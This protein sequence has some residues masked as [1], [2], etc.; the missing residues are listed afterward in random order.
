MSYGEKPG[1]VS[2]I[3]VSSAFGK[4]HA[5]ISAEVARLISQI[6][7]G[8]AKDLFEPTGVDLD[9]SPVYTMSRDGFMLVSGTWNS[10]RAL[11]TKLAFLDELGRMGHCGMNEQ[12]TVLF[13][14][15]H[16]GRPV[17]IS[18]TV[19]LGRDDSAMPRFSL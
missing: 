17:S 5:A 8:R 2:T 7:W 6:G 15:Q 11:R 19:N 18:V 14:A 3:R 1:W 4:R 12:N 16:N 9:G 13:D 10:T